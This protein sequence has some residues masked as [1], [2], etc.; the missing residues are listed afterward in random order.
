VTLPPCIE[1]VLKE[2]KDVMSEE[3]YKGIGQVNVLLAL[4]GR[5]EYLIVHTSIIRH[6]HHNIR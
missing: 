4:H 6:G 1:K 3:F 2:N 5:S